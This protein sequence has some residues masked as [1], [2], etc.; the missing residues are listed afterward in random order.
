MFEVVVRRDSAGIGVKLPF[1]VVERVL[2]DAEFF[3]REIQRRAGRAADH[4]RAQR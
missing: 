2:A 4:S 3:G 1:D